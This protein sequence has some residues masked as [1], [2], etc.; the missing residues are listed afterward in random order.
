MKYAYRSVKLM[1]V[2]SASCYCLFFPCLL[3]LLP[4]PLW[5]ANETLPPPRNST[6]ESLLILLPRWHSAREARD[7]G[8]MPGGRKIPCKR[9]W[10]PSPVF[11]PGKSHGQR[12]Q[13][14]TVHAVTKESDMTR[15]RTHIAF[16][17][18]FIILPPLSPIFISSQET[19]PPLRS[20]F[21]P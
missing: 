20:L 6:A 3:I 13:Q 10:Q 8:L 11:L 5:E 21:S 1:P 17:F 9:K 7:W 16:F 18:L 12:I 4:F 15:T 14:A 2:K 19:P